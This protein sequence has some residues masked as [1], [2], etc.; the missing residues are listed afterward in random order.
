MKKKYI[1]FFIV[2]VVVDILWV[3]IPNIK[4]IHSYQSSRMEMEHQLLEYDLSAEK[5]KQDDRDIEYWL[6]QLDEI[7]KKEGIVI[8]NRNFSMTQNESIQLSLELQC[9]KI[10]LK[11]LL[12]SSEWNKGRYKILSINSSIEENQYLN[13]RIEIL[14][15]N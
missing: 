8:L 6:F 2:F 13:T 12:E 4:S 3:I 15:K 7:M 14:I 11:K 5:G 10:Q 1:I 9:S